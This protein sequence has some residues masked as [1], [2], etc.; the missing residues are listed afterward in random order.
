MMTMTNGTIMISN[1][2]DRTNQMCPELKPL[3]EFLARYAAQLMGAGATCMRVHRNIKRIAEAYGAEVE[4]MTLSAH[5]IVEVRR[6]SDDTSYRT[7]MSIP[8]CPISFYINSKLSNLS[9]RIVQNSIPLRHAR[10]MFEIIIRARN[11][12]SNLLIALVAAA[13][14][15]FC[16]LFGGD[17][18]AMVIVACAT[19]LGFYIKSLM[20]RNADMRIAVIV[21]AF[22]SAVIGSGGYA[23]AWTSTPSV[24][25]GTSVLYL[26]PGI[27]YLNCVSDFFGGHYTSSMARLSKSLMLTVCIAIG[28]TAGYLV[29]QLSIP[30]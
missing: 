5:V 23:F 30:E 25:L 22:L 29:M 8:H 7:T 15:S 12:N 24:A 9:W 2:M 14:A 21:S 13:N 11:I 18:G 4:L 3:S 26:I 16:R 27:P 19:A 1:N 20:S 28:L 6:H 10:R 17:P